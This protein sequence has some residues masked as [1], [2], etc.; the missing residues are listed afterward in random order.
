MSFEPYYTWRTAVTYFLALLTLI[1]CCAVMV[2]LG[3]AV[4]DYIFTDLPMDYTD[5]EPPATTV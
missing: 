4:L 3:W 5:P 1:V 2:V